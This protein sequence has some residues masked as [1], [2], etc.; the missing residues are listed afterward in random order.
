MRSTIPDAIKFQKW[1]TRELLPKVF[2][3]G[4]YSSAPIETTQTTNFYDNNLMTQYEHRR[5]IYLAYI[6]VDKDDNCPMLKI[7][8]SYNFIV[9]ELKQHRKTFSGEYCFNIQHIQIVDAI[10][11]VEK[12]LLIECQAKN[13]L[14]S[15]KNKWHNS[16]RNNKIES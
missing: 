3:Y 2:A 12:K 8:K 13:I 14:C 7:G 4:T 15:K 1:I 10:D 6:G 9:R 16:D 11:E 5:V